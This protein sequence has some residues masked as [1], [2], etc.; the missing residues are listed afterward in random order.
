[1]GESE[2]EAVIP[3]KRLEIEYGGDRV[4]VGLSGANTDQVA[5]LIHMGIQI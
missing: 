2:D 3:A 1:M 4:Q 5:D